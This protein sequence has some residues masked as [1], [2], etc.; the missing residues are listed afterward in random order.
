MTRLIN[1]R[2]CLHDHVASRVLSVSTHSLNNCTKTCCLPA[3]DP[4]RLVWEATWLEPGTDCLREQTSEL[5]GRYQCHNGQDE[6]FR[7]FSWMVSINILQHIDYSQDFYSWKVYYSRLHLIWAG[8]I[9]WWMLRWMLMDELRESW[10]SI[11]CML[12]VVKTKITISSWPL[13]R[14]GRRG[15]EDTIDFSLHIIAD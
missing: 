6:M 1:L 8:L 9:L 7:S 10:T 14:W 12:K 3:E 2:S 4:G 11:S 13:M 15:I 5:P